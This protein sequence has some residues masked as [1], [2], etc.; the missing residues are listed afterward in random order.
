AVGPGTKDE[1]MKVKVAGAE[2]VKATVILISEVSVS[3]G[4]QEKPLI[5]KAKP[6]SG[7]EGA[8]PTEKTQFDVILKSKVVTGPE[9]EF[10]LRIPDEQFRRI[11][12]GADFELKLKVKPPKGFEYSSDEAKV[13]LNQASGPE[14]ELILFWKPDP[15]KAASN[16][17]TSA[18]SP[19]GQQT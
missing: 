4:A 6:T 8:A 1:E 16:K 2:I 3:V 14:F 12:A 5:L 11:P 17:G 10:T 7:G 9:G 19:E 18:I 13:R 15:V